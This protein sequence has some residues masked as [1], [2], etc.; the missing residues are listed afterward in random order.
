MK[1]ITALLIC[2]VYFCSLIN[3][4]VSAD[5]SKDEFWNDVFEM[6]NRYEEDQYFSVM[7]VKIGESDINID[8][9]IVP[10]DESKS[11]PYVE[12]GRTMMP[13]RGLA[14]AIGADVSFDA[15][16]QTVTVETPETMVLMTIGLDEMEVNGESVSLLNAPEIVND[17]TMLPVRDVAE[18]LDCEVEW[19]Q[20][21][22]TAVF[23]RPLQ[24][25]RIIAF[26]E[27]V[28][29]DDAVMT[30]SGEGMTVM[31]FDSIDETREALETLTEC[32]I[33]AE[34]D[35]VRKLSAMSWGIDDIGSEKYY[36]ETDYA[37][38]SAVVAIVDTGID[39]SHSFFKG[40]LVNGYDI[41]DNDSNPQDVDGHGT[42]VASTVLDVAGYN[43]KIKVMPVKVFADGDEYTTSGAIA[44]GI[45]YAVDHGAD[46]INLSVGGAHTSDVEQQAVNYAYRNNVAVVAAA[47]NE[48]LNLDNNAYVPAGLDH[49]ITVS[50]MNEDGTLA[51]FSNYG[52]SKLEFTAPGVL[53]KGAKVG[54]G[55]CTKSGTSMASPH[56]AGAYAIV[57]AVHPNI[58][59]DEITEALKKN[60]KEKGNASYFGYGM[61]K[62]NALEK[63]LSS[64][65]CDNEKIES[66][67]DNSAVLSGT[68]RYEG[69]TPEYVGARLGTS[70]NN[71][72]DVVK[73]RF[74]DNGNN[75]MNFKCDLTSLKSGTTYYVCVFMKPGGFDYVSEDIEF[76][77]TGK[78]AKPEPEPMPEPEPDKSELRILPNKYP[79]GEMNEGSS[80]GLSGRI[81]SNCHITDVRSYILDSNYKVLQESSGWTTTQ[82]YV[83]ED[84][85]L[86]TGLKFGKLSPGTYYL[87][88]YAEDETGNSVTWTSDAFRIVANQPAP[89]PKPDPVISEL[90]ILPD[91]YPTG[92]I[93]QG[94]SYG[95]SGRIKSNC[96]ITDVRAYMLDSNKNVIMEASGWT[97]TQTYVIENSALDKGMKFDQLSAGTYYLKYVAS[98][99]SGN[100]VSWT[101]DPFTVAGNVSKSELRILPDK[102]PT[103]TLTKGK[104]F[105]LSGRIK[106]NCHIT[107][108]RAYLLDSNKN[109]IMEASGWTTTQTYV[110]EGSALDKGM[111]FNNLSAGGYYL[112]YVASDESGNT[113][114]WTSEMFYVK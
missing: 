94:S 49:V 106:S 96:H 19:V 74:K 72:T 6:I 68:I 50:A 109:V 11:V 84:S 107:D 111:K 67:S 69:I 78:P 43:S 64:V 4:P 21:T 31:Q 88:Y 98:D 86:D 77:T 61:I 44:R 18:A 29:N 20:E 33:K 27:D 79:T 103:G 63:Y 34:P 112:K 28:K 85:K 70:R 60:A 113:I 55:Y 58:S 13:V 82:T 51:S 108:V 2:L 9:E 87:R 62:V 53:I 102:Y 57:K 30:V 35:Y 42:H 114:S 105:G 93:S 97:T 92:Q 38:G 26:Q 32:G 90:R 75:T 54:G 41:Y 56:V 12:N 10:I 71:Q 3:I 24:T 22:E 47:G 17:R 100:T 101:S 104:S 45:E 39:L 95:L 1:K 7:S 23:T 65:W 52:Q 5:N 66:V 89:E 83:I 110:I 8:G 59:V 14:E 15:E 37:A 25:K 99:E 76:T 46:V 73:V 91:K 48:K 40:K 80:Y 16:E 81:K 36:N